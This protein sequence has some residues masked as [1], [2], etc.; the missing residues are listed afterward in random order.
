MLGAK[1]GFIGSVGKD[2]TG[3]FFENDMKMAGVK[4]FLSRRIRENTEKS[5][6][7]SFE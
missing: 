4:T 2:D 5:K 3:D 1:T 7:S 6:L